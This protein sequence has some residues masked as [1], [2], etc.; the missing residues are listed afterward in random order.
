[1]PSGRRRAVALGVLLMTALPA[2]ARN[3]AWERAAGLT[4]RW[5]HVAI[6]IVPVSN[7]T[8]MLGEDLP[9][10]PTADDTIFFLEG[11]S[12]DLNGDREV[13][14]LTIGTTDS[15]SFQGGTLTL[16]SIRRDDVPGGENNHA[17][18]VPLVFS[19]ASAEVTVRGSG[20]LHLSGPIT[21]DRL[22]K[23]GTSELVISNPSVSLN[24]IDIAGGTLRL[25]STPTVTRVLPGIT[26]SGEAASLVV[27][28]PYR[29]GAVTAFAALERPSIVVRNAVLL[30]AERFSSFMRLSGAT[31]ARAR[32]LLGEM[33]V[34][35]TLA[36]N[37]ITFEL[38]GWGGTGVHVDLEQGAVLKA[39]DDVTFPGNSLNLLV[40]AKHD[41][42]V[43]DTGG[44]LF[45]VG[46][47]A[48]EG[49]SRIRKVGTGTLDGYAGGLEELI[50]EDGTVVLRSFQGLRGLAFAGV[51]STIP[52]V[53]V[54]QTV[55][56][57]TATRFRFD[58]SGVVDLTEPSAVATTTAALSGGGLVKRG[59]G[60]LAFHGPA[61]DFVGT[62]IVE[63]G[64][65]E[66]ATTSAARA[67]ALVVT[68]GVVRL[69][70]EDTIDPGTQISVFGGVLHVDARNP[71]RHLTIGPGELIA[72][73]GL[74]L[75]PGGIGLTLAAGSAAIEDLA[76]PVSFETPSGA[77]PGTVRVSVADGGTLR[78]SGTVAAPTAGLRKVGGGTLVLAANNFGLEQ[79]IDLE[80]G[81]LAAAMPFAFSHVVGAGIRFTGGAL[82]FD[83]DLIFL[84]ALELAGAGER[85]LDLN[86]H[87]GLTG[88]PITG[89]AGLRVTGPGHFNLTAASTFSGGLTV[90][91]GASIIPLS[92][93]ALGAAAGKLTLDGGSLR[94]QDD[95]TLPGSRTVILGAGGGT[96]A[97]DRDH[98]LTV[99]TA[100][101]GAGRLTIDGPGAA[102]L[103]V[104]NLHLGGTTVRAA[105]VRIASS[106][107]LGSAANKMPV[108][109]LDG[110]RLRLSGAVP[111]VLDHAFEIEG[112]VDVAVDAAVRH[113]IGGFVGGTGT[114][115]KSGAGEL[116]LTGGVG[117]IDLAVV[118]GE[119]AV[120]ADDTLVIGGR[121]DVADGAAFVAEG[122]ENFSIVLL[123]NRVG[124]Q[125]GI[126]DAS[127]DVAAFAAE[128]AG[129][130]TIVGGTTSTSYLATVDVSAQG[131]GAAGGPGVLVL[132]RGRHELGRPSTLVLDIVPDAADHLVLVDGATLAI[133][134]NLALRFAGDA[135]D[136][137]G[138]S[139]T[140]FEGGAPSGAFA[141]IESA[142][143]PAG[144]V[145]DDSRLYSAGIVAI[146]PVPEPAQWVLMASGLGLLIASCRWRR[147]AARY[148][149]PQ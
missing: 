33:G 98:T 138:R 145:V 62:M 92:D 80:E 10:L 84:P 49:T 12:I 129:H 72:P 44:H 103:A 130:G 67:S 38:T 34:L 87:T 102:V 83:E 143:L 113:R 134:G 75:A 125:G 61:A 35:S 18:S 139:F 109:L 141:A 1:M 97:I 52:V 148:P 29:L 25:A 112:D 108:S 17:I 15:V 11:S 78:L 93:D 23:R 137:L 63:D 57:T 65:L 86:G 31:G 60:K 32:G 140:L 142:G 13:S 81:V 146:A 20:F 89:T 94:A 55:P 107:A 4:D 59:P 66:L 124:L 50:V 82:R 123:E 36:L 106:G 147:R 122:G 132:S 91:D 19:S 43:V 51:A 111:L 88:K 64:E 85:V 128:V 22:V 16:G 30:E 100:I 24:G 117:D 131:P 71:M 14:G 77:T 101:G 144:L 135:N 39:V 68:G 118:S 41:G 104:D 2:S 37:N 73:D 96:F 56:L 127:L 116:V 69:S 95:L 114:L 8:V 105:E 3:L 5:D 74:V 99:A 45:Q 48:G 149:Q 115:T 126:F 90:V 47:L 21:G 121:V 79:R 28:T 110:S 53:R 27:D 7:W 46:G 76:G 40:T 119:L 136:F 58:H 9:I 6:Q 54:S 26:F 120:R 42:V 70:G 133:G